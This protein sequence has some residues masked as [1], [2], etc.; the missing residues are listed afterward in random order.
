MNKKY[1]YLV[2]VALLVG[3]IISLLAS[4]SPDGLEKVAKDKGFIATALEYP[5][6]TLMPDYV[7]PVVASECLATALAGIVGTALVF[8][9]VFGINKALFCKK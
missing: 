4:S 5:F 9:V 3:G 8:T 7:F 1:V 6:T 2:V